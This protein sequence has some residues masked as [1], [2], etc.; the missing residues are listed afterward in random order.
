MIVGL[1]AEERRENEK[2]ER[3]HPRPRRPYF[4]TPEELAPVVP[5]KSVYERFET[6]IR[7]YGSEYRVMVTP[8][9]GWGDI[10]GF[11]VMFQIVIDT[12]FYA[13]L[14]YVVVKWEWWNCSPEGPFTPE[15]F[16]NIIELWFE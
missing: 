2:W 1:S 6:V 5:K 14:Q 10:H 7:R 13:N 15:Q 12:S 8:M 4:Y 3:E 9:P 11:P 16:G